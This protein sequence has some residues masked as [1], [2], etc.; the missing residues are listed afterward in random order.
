LSVTTKGHVVVAGG[1]GFVGSHL[2][3]RLLRDGWRVTSIDDFSTGNMGN[4]GHLDGHR[5]FTFVQH[6]VT[7]PLPPLEHVD[8]I[9]HLA[10]PASPIDYSRLAIE[11]LKAGS[12]GTFNLLML[13]QMH[14]ARFVLAS[15]SE[16]YGDPLVHPQNEGYWGN[17]NPVGPRSMYDEA[18]RFA[19][20]LTVAFAAQ[21]GIS[22]GIARLF[23]CYGPR[24]NPKDGRAIP[25]FI[26]QALNGA[27]LTVAGDGSQTRSA[28]YV[29]DI[30]G[31]F[32]ALMMSNYQQPVNFGNTEEITILD[33]AY[34]IC[35]ITGS[36]SRVDFIP[37]PVD[38]PSLRRP[39]ITRARRVL[40]WEP[41]TS[42]ADGIESTVEW[43]QELQSPTELRRDT[44]ASIQSNGGG[45]RATPRSDT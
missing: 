17:V 13:A 11:T 36:V 28:C 26:W 37:R 18:K 2:T 4:L 7:N 32:C 39:D 43:F 25:T 12:I 42:L 33:L 19:E 22:V 31:G 5:L 35:Q 38:D 15:T 44:T 16:V 10:S 27:P 21:H 23:N 40:G 34:K 14:G 41:R 1:A 3:D 20:A 9:F 8:A 30:V 6:D 29:E 24:M 45:H